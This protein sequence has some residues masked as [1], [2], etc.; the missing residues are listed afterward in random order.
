MHETTTGKTSKEVT[1]TVFEKNYQVAYTL[2]GISFDASIGFD[3]HI[4]EQLQPFDTDG[5][6]AFHPGYLSGFYAEIGDADKKEYEAYACEQFQDYTRNL[7]IESEGSEAKNLIIP[8]RV[9][10]VSHALHPVWFMSYRRKNELIYAAVNGQTGKVA[11]DLPLSPLR[12]L[13]AALLSVLLIFGAVNLVMNLLPS[14]KAGATLMICSLLTFTYT[15][16]L[17]DTYL[18]TLARCL[19][20]P[21]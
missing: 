17:Q 15:A 13:L 10:S 19:H 3:D 20:M 1:T 14:I 2:S 18:T 16:L 11:A 6:K 8:T 9:Q 21:I 7:I 4:S 12:I 5:Q